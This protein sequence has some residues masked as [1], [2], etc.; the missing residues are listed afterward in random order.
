M[1]KNLKECSP[2][3]HIKKVSHWANYKHIK[4]LSIYHFLNRRVFFWIF[5]KKT[6]AVL[7]VEAAV[8]V[9]V[10]ILF[11]CSM[12][13]ILDCYRIYRCALVLRL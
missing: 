1:N 13:G 2:G 10:V 3:I 12:M 6:K 7:T 11:F 4:S 8:V 5:R 9:P